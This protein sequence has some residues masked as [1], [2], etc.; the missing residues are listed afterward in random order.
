MKLYQEFLIGQDSEV[1]KEI[2][3]T[4]AV[5]IRIGEDEQK[6]V[7]LIQRDSNDHFPLH[8]ETPRG[9][10]DK[11]DKNKLHECLKREVK[12]ETGLNVNIL[13]YIGKFEYIAEEGKRK[14]TQYNYLCSMK[15]PK[16][17]VKLSKE[18]QDYKWI[19]N[20]SQ[21]ELLCLPEIKRLISRVLNNDSPI[22]NYPK[23]EEVIEETQRS[24]TKLKC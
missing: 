24:W 6:E 5:I 23:T 8:W 1:V 12:E 21:A 2:N 15:N 16:Q 7:L 13:K 17:K 9:K 18:H 14:S 22:V 3:V 10:C 4:G 11:G 20:T 19:S